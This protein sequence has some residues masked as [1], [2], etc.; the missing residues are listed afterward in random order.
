MS[1]ITPRM[2]MFA[3]P[4]ASG[5]STL[6][7]VLP[8]ELLG[9]YLNPDEIEAKIQQTGFLEL[10]AFGV[11]TTED[12]ILPW[13]RKSSL[14]Q[15]DGLPD[16]ANRLHFSEGK[17]YFKDVGVDSY[18]ASVA[19]D[20]MRYKLLDRKESFTFE[21]VMSHASKVE[22]LEKAQKLGYR[23]YLY[24]IATED[25]EIN[26]SRVRNR[27]KLGGHDVPENRI[28]ARYYRS[29][30][31]LMEAIKHTNRAYLFDNS[32][33]S[34]DKTWLAEITDGK[35]LEMKTDQ[36]PAWFKH[37]LLDKIGRV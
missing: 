3:G 32:G 17:L 6:K 26:I 20:F 35:T 33:E 10:S 9:I 29:L 8:H 34:K 25:P 2:R 27:V 21:T 1:L 13:F 23:T 22:L 14:L 28:V 30:D 19:T 18:F 36:A 24:Y 12:E 5:K 7:S 11:T 16:A 4:N 15:S 31:L 37:Y